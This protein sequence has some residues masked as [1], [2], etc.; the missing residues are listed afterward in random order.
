MSSALRCEDALPQQVEVRS[1]I[2]LPLQE[3]E[4]IHLALGLA[5]AVGLGA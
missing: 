5:V 1:T 2:H 4:S 3:L